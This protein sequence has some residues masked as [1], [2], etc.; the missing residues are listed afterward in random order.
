MSRYRRSVAK[1]ASFFFTVN[2]YVRRGILPA[3]WTVDPG[4]VVGDAG[5]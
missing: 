2:A 4:E 3:D 5:E 1:G